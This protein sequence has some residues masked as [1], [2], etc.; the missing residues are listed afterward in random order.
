MSVDAPTTVRPGEKP[1]GLRRLL[2][3]FANTCKGFAGAWREEEAF[4]QECLLALVVVPLG[5][6]LGP[7]GVARTLLVSPML[8]VLIVELLN[9]AVEA[10]IDRIG[11]E[12]HV[13]SGLAK[14]LG[15]AAVF[16]SFLLL[17]LSWVL[18]LGDR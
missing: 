11:A 2:G 6:W 3:A 16:V 10:A 5:L 17:G 4:R 7:T 12:R 8:L 18:V 14:D 13:L 1:R 9:S 15:S